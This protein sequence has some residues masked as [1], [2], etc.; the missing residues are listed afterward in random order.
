MQLIEFLNHN[1]VN[2]QL[3]SHRPTYTAQHMAAEEHTPGMNVAKPVVVEADKKY[4]MCVLPACCKAAT[5]VRTS[6]PSTE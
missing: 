3:C 4:Y 6:L 1:K 2:F 5:R